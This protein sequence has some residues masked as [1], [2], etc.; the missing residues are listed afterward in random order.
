MK[1]IDVVTSKGYTGFYFDDQ[2]AIKNGALMDGF[3]YIGDVLTDKFSHIR[4]T[5]ES[6][7]IMLIL[8]DGQIAYGDAAAVQ[9]SGA[10]GRD[11]LFLAEEGEAIFNS[12]LKHLLIGLDISTFKKNAEYFDHLM[13]DNKR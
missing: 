1:I 2:A 8:E 13:I 10:G 6:L 11:P 5:G 3:M 9:Y 7:S 4:Q 12:H